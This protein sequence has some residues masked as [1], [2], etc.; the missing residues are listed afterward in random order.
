[1]KKML[2]AAAIAAVTVPA[3]AAN[4]NLVDGD[5]IKLG[6]K[7][8][9]IVEIDA[10]ETYKPRC[11]L[12]RK[13]G[14]ETKER[15]R[16][17]LDAGDVTY[18]ATGTDRYGRTLAHVYAGGVNVG[19]QLMMEGRALRYRPGAMAKAERVS[20][21]CGVDA[22]TEV[23]KAAQPQQA[24]AAAADS[25]MTYRNCKEARAA[26]AAAL[27]AGSPGYSSKLDRDGDGVACE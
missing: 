25:D 13:L 22:S 1:M 9:R 23:F 11:E 24:A 15:L 6:G 8:I 4:V 14:Y 7:T 10:P 2:L 12:E 21:W 26:G 3:H 5:T 16:Q 18:E 19:E 20:I 27:Y 17:L